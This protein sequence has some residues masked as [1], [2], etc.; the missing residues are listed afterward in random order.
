MKIGIIFYSLSRHTL[1]LS[2]QIKQA[3][4]QDGHTVQTTQLEPASYQVRAQKA[5]LKSIPPVTGYD[6]LILACPVH[7][8]R[9]APPMQALIEKTPSLK[10]MKVACLITQVFP[11]KWGGEQTLAAMREV[12]ESKGARIVTSGGVSWYSFAR[13]RQILAIL[14]DLKA[15]IK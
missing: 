13:R 6:L 11:R 12:C 4:E 14:D 8:G 7:G 2:Q 9:M 15:A 3:L 5:E 10:N 1:S